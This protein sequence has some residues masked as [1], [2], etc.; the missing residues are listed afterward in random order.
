MVVYTCE[1]CGC[2]ELIVVHQYTLTKSYATEVPCSCEG[3]ANGIASVSQSHVT[4]A[5]EVRGELDDTHHWHESD[6]EEIEQVEDEEDESEVFCL[7]CSQENAESSIVEEEG[8]P[9][10]G[11][12]EFYVRCADCDREIEFGWSHPDQMGR[13]WPVESSDF[14]PWKS[15]PEPRYRDAWAAKDWLRPE[16]VARD[17]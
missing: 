12:H 10:P 16:S 4:T 11:D 6:D 8:E 2:H 15:W 9:E 3:A 13:I 7:S 1:Q 5:F 14:N 17:D